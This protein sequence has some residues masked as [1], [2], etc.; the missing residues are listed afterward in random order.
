MTIIDTAT[1]PAQMIEFKALGNVAA[2]FTIRHNVSIF[3]SP[4]DLHCCIAT[5]VIG[6]KPQHATRVGLWNTQPF[7]PFLNGRHLRLLRG[8][9][10]S[11]RFRW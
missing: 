2:N 1:N 9:C 3:R 11:H 8:G 10:Q 5:S 4:F 6:A 7:K